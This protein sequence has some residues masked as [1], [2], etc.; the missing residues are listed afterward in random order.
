MP[1]YSVNCPDGQRR[2]VEPFANEAD[3][4]RWADQG[5]CC[6]SP[7]LHTIIPVCD[8]GTMLTSIDTENGMCPSCWRETFDLGPDVDLATRLQSATLWLAILAAQRGDIDSALGHYFAY[9]AQVRRQ[10]VT[11]TDAMRSHPGMDEVRAIW[12]SATDRG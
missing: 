5:H 3:A 1:I 10:G 11:A 4:Y 6:M 8:C 12:R 9:L 7:R 2:H